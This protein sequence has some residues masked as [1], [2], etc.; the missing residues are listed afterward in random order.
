VRSRALEWLKIFDFNIDDKCNLNHG[1]DNNGIITAKGSTI[2]M[3]IPT[4]EE[5]MIAKDSAV[6]TQK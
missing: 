2:A 6:L 3:V 5:W 4:N 1:K